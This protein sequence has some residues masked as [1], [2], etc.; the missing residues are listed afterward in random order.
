MDKVLKG[1]V[2][3][4]N[5]K[6]DLDMDEVNCDEVFQLRENKRKEMET[7]RSEEDDEILREILEEERQ[8]KKKIE[9]E[10][11]AQKKTKKKK[12]SKKSD[13]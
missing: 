7:Q 6:E 13:L 11:D 5:L 12:G 3:V 2:E 8:R 10:L 1:K 4:H 9:E